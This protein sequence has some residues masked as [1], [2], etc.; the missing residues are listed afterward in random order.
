M[1]EKSEL[2]NPQKAYFNGKFKEKLQKAPGVQAEMEQKPD[3]GEDSYQG[4]NRLA[5]SPHAVRAVGYA[6]HQ[7]R[8][9]DNVPW[10]RVVYKDGGMAFA[11]AGQRVLLAAEGTVFTDEGKV[12]MAVCGWDA[13]EIEAE[14]FF[15]A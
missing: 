14:L 1:N 8:A 13:A 5:G 3:C 15:N 9:E 10:Q 12:D 11:D 4:C 6:L 7:A 2:I